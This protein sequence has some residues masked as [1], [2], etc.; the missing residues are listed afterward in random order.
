MNQ[1]LYDECIS[2]V[3]QYEDLNT[4][5]Q[6]IKLKKDIIEK[7]LTLNTKKMTSEEFSKFAHESG[8]FNMKDDE[9][10]GD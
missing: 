3:Q 1:E 7:Q 6:D 2:L 4:E 9:M 5:E 8:Y 10:L